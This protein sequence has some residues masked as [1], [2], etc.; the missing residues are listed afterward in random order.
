MKTRLLII[1]GIALV[2]SLIIS[3]VAYPATQ[4]TLDETEFLEIKNNM[5]SLGYHICDVSLKENKITLTLNWIFEGT[6]HEKI[7]LSQIPS[8]VNYH[9]KY[10]DSYSDYFISEESV[11][12]CE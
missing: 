5:E 6:E 11:H 7:I 10:D 12:S 8:N 1:V 2:L 3:Y 9:I 4:S